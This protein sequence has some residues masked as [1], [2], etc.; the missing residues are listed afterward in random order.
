M[1]HT[2]P[3]T[4]HALAAAKRGSSLRC[5]TEQKH[6]NFSAIYGSAQLN[7]KLIIRV[8]EA[9]MSHGNISGDDF[10]LKNANLAEIF[11]INTSTLVHNMFYFFSEKLVNNMFYNN[12][13]Y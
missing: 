9:I 13:S 3:R 5:A 7:I 8:S 4:Q 10:R 12:N 2:Q 6:N 11:F 1:K